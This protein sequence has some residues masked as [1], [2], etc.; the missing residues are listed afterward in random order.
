MKLERKHLSLL[1]MILIANISATGIH[2]TD[3][4]R[5][6]EQYPEPAWITAASIYQSWL[7]LSGV[8]IAGY[9]LVQV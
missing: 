3:N 8:G 1:K 9:W 5:F 4:Y 6:I 2:F 7:L